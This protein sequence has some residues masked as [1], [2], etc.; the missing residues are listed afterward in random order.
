MVR[1]GQGKSRSDCLIAVSLWVTAKIT[2]P[3]MRFFWNGTPFD[4][5]HGADS[6]WKTVERNA[7]LRY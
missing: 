3:P 2:P 6:G 5:D 1:T 4:R 7:L